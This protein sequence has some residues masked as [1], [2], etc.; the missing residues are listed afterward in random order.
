M[1]VERLA[2]IGDID[3]GSWND[4]L[5]DDNPF[6]RH[7]FLFA[8]EESGSASSATGWQPRHLLYRDNQG[9]ISA[10]MPLY[11]KTH[12][13]GEFVFDWAW[14][15]AYERAE[16]A[17][18]PKLLCAV[19]FSPVRGARILGTQPAA[20]MAAAR[21]FAVE[22]NTVSLEC[23][24]ACQRSPCFSQRFVEFN[25]TACRLFREPI[26]LSA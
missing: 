20:M 7:A 12:S 11:V 15:D 5:T 10:G 9:K 19:P 25:G 17:Y 8:M 16:L 13:Y 4:L 22:A 18:Y 26:E 3:P 24:E 1:P 6:L 2:G 21:S 23:Y 14:A